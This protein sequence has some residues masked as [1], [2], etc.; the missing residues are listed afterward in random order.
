MHSICF[1]TAVVCL[2]QLLLLPPELMAQQQTGYYL[3]A[4]RGGIVNDSMPENSEASINAAYHQG[5]R[6]V[7][8]DLRLTRDKELIIYHDSDFRKYF[9]DSRKVVDLDWSEISKLN[10]GNHRVLKLEE[11]LRLC[12]GKLHVMID[13]KIQGN[14]T[15][16]WNRLLALLKEYNLQETALMIGTSASTEFF[17]G[18]IKLSCTRQQLETNM[19]QPG[20]RPDNYYLFGNALTTEDVQW[21]G[22]HNILAVGVVN[23]WIF[24]RQNASPD[25]ILQ[26]IKKLKNSGLVYF[27]IDADYLHY[28]TP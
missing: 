15:L 1:S 4:H 20:Y 21:A 8:I 3:I 26:Q 22:R 14:D 5:F 19:K 11:A 27:Q 16:V 13:N 7:E 24:Q 23:K 12:Q 10:N 28:F 25:E 17:T 6:M 9:G 2:L 18:K